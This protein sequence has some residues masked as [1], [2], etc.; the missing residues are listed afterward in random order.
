MFLRINKK[1]NKMDWRRTK[2]N[3]TLIDLLKQG[4]IEYLNYSQKLL[5]IAKINFFYQ[6]ENIKKDYS[7]KNSLIE[8]FN[9]KLK[10]NFNEIISNFKSKIFQK[11]ETEEEILNFE[12]EIEKEEKNF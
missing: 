6:S 9:S 12:A 4:F 2:Q 11:F 5:I 3:L 1:I 8:K 10:E 7:Q